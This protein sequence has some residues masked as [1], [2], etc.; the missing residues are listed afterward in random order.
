LISPAVLATAAR[1][2]QAFEAARP[3]KH[4]CIDGFFLP[5]A[6]A[7]LL[8]DFPPFDREFARNEFGEYGGKAVIND[9]AAISPFYARLYDYLMSPAFLSAM[10]ALTGIADLHGDPRLYGGGTH[11]NIDGQELDVHVDFNYRIE[12]GFH[13]RANLLLYLN[14]QWEPAWGGAIELHADPRRPERDALKAFNVIFNRAVI[15]ETNEHSWHGFRKIELPADRRHLSRKC[16]SIYLYT[17]TRPAR[18]IAGR[19][20][21]FYIQ[22]PFPPKFTA[23]H[24]LSEGDVAELRTGYARRDRQLEM[25][26]RLEDRLV[27]EIE[28][29][30]RSIGQPREVFDTAGD[31]CALTVDFAASGNSLRYLG[32]GWAEPEELHTWAVGSRSGLEL[33]RPAVRGSYVLACEVSPHCW[34]GMPDQRLAMAVNG[35]EVGRF[36]LRDGAALECLVPWPVLAESQKLSMVFLHPDA[37]RPSAVSG[38]GDERELAFAFIR[39]TLFRLFEPGEYTWRGF[40]CLELPADPSHPPRRPPA[41]YLYAADRPAAE[42]AAA[43]DAYFVAWPFP[44]KF[45]S[46]RVLCEADVAELRAGYVRRD[47]QIALY[48]HLEERLGRELEQVE[49]CI[50]NVDGRGR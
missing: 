44:D 17:P 30:R 49:L 4:V 39:L 37:A 14:E 47:G 26:R 3:F 22:W 24:L 27:G 21:T 41:I 19:H 1:Y 42:G 36:R 5:D 20:G 18:E 25:Y 7:A 31:S 40:R 8:R 6:A 23:G 48:Q 32:E 15:F 16:L 28:Q 35:C 9:I 10:S 43:R 29:L 46:G 33:P 45:T 50:R 12:G 34:P 38:S 11:E 13:R 2:R